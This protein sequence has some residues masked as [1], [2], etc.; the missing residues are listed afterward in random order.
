MSHTILIADDEEEIRELLSLYMEKERF[1]VL[2]AANGLEVLK[3]LEEHTVDL[4]L[5]DIMM[6]NMNGLEALKEIRKS[7]YIPI[8]LL[9]AKGEDYDKILG[10]GLGADDYIS[11]PFNPLEVTARVGAQLRRYHR[12]GMVADEADSQGLIRSGEL[13]LDQESCIVTRNGEELP[14]TSMEYKI[15]LLLMR[16]PGKVFTKRKIFESVW[17]EAYYGDDNT[18]MVHIS[19]IRE[20]LEVDP[21]NPVYIKTVRGIG[22]KWEKQ[23]Q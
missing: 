21:R 12:F 13:T 7:Q 1:K 20:K 22:Y 3:L 17:E 11:K 14:L 6:P 23:V 10:L 5:L 19:K 4:I 15:A 2:E 16:H 18:I 8:I 9:S